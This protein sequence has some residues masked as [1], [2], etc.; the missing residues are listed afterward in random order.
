MLLNTLLP[1]T[2]LA[3]A[4]LAI[5][6]DTHLSTETTVFCSTTYGKTH[7]S[8]IPTTTSISPTTIELSPVIL[9]NSTTLTKTVTPKSFNTLFSILTTKTKWVTS[10]PVNGTFYTTKTK[11]GTSTFWHHTTTT[12][13]KTEFRYLTSRTTEWIAAPTGFMP[14]RNTTFAPA[15][16]EGHQKR[17][18]SHPH[19]ARASFKIPKPKVVRPTSGKFAVEVGCKQEVRVHTTEVLML[20]ETKRAT[21]TLRP[22]TVFKNRTVYGTITSTVFILSFPSSSASSSSPSSILAREVTTAAESAVQSTA[23]ASPAASTTSESAAST[24]GSSSTSSASDSA[25]STSGSAASSAAS[26]TSSTSSSTTHP[27]LPTGANGIAT[28]L[29]HT[30]TTPYTI[31]FTFTATSTSTTTLTR[32]ATTTIT[33]HSACATS[34]LLSQTSKNRRINGVSMLDGGRVEEVEVKTAGE[35]FDLAV[36]RI[37]SNAT[38]GTADVLK[39][40]TYLATDVSAHLMFGE[41]FHML[42]SGKR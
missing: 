27:P 13:T 11:F 2:L 8:S 22:E 6:I 25:S 38:S 19:A 24:S 14:V 39:W 7:L 21:V 15:E 40:W 10:T 41:S 9:H 33:S 32:H 18:L 42:E 36:A 35:C 23:V 16:E 34:N 30:T 28:S 3:P 5:S 31:T 1:W 4:A 20:T 29:A 37:K 12:K 26:S 17:E